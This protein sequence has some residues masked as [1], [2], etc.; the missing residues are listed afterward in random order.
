M[1]EYKANVDVKLFKS[2][3]YLYRDTVKAGT[4]VSTTDSRDG[5]IQIATP[6][7]F[8]TY[9]GEVKYFT[10]VVPTEPI[11]PVDP[12]WPDFF[13]LENPLGEKQKYN[14]EV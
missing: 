11:D 3:S 6:V 5:W 10:L 4:I 13:Y 8:V 1:A 12:T 14:K 2:P 9:W 7:K